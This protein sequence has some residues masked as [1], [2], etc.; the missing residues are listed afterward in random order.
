LTEKTTAELLQDRL[1]EHGLVRVLSRQDVSPDIVKELPLDEAA[2]LVQQSFV[3]SPVARPAK[4]SAK[5]SG[6]K[7]VAK[8]KKSKKAAKAKKSK[9]AAKK[10]GGPP[11][12]KP[13]PHRKYWLRVKRELHLLLCTNDRK[14]ASVRRN[15][16]TEGKAT[17]AF[18]ASSITTA[19]VPF[20][21]ASATIIGPLVTIGLIALLRV[22][23][24]AWCA[25][26]IE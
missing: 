26:Q 10:N 3:P 13:A 4:K 2:R 1:T 5:K 25:G 20:A 15:L 9:K 6:A 8:A 23:T 16:G 18:I 21:G 11:R 12:A 24:S 17:Q 22:G 19:V 7:K 14:Y